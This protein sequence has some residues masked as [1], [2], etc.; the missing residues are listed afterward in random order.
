MELT[1]ETISLILEN[2]KDKKLKEIAEILEKSEGW[3]SRLKKFYE[4]DEKQKEE[5]SLQHRQFKYLFTLYKEYKQRKS[6][7]LLSLRKFTEKDYI[8]S[9]LGSYFLIKHIAIEYNILKKENEIL[10]KENAEDAFE[11]NRKQNQISELKKELELKEKKVKYYTYL[12]YASIVLNI[13]TIV[14]ILIKG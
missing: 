10:I 11:I 8:Q 6:N 2:N 7:K 12:Y 9:L 13:F 3:V 1:W 14:S 5:L 4:A